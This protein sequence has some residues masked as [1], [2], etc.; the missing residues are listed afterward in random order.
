MKKF[1]VV[2]FVLLF[3]Q[4]AM[5]GNIKRLFQDVKLPTQQVLEKQTVGHP[6]VATTN[7]ILTTNAGPTSGAAVTVSSFAHQPD[8]PRNLTITP[9]S[10]TA[11][12]GTCTI[13]V[14]GTNI[15][16]ATIT[17]DFAFAAN[18]SSATTGAKAF[19][20]VTSIAW[21]ASC[22]D[23]PYTASWTVGVGELLGLKRCM[24]SAGDLIRSLKDGA[25]EATQPTCTA[26]DNEVEKNVC[27]VSGTMDN[28]AV[29]IFYFIQNYQCMP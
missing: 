3:T 24:A 14:T 25:T 4:F 26:D 10:T 1:G 22:E 17:E 18:A 16:G 6:I 12:V 8:V 9:G 7:Y 21:A 15:L 13:T 28:S 19:K 5:A 11:D 2:V 23:S 29:W 27:D 20:T